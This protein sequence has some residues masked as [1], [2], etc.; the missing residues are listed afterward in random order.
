MEKYAGSNMPL[1]GLP[2]AGKGSAP[3][4]AILSIVLGAIAAL[5]VNTLPVLLTVLARTLS[6]DESQS[7][8]VAFAEM[9]GIA[10]GTIGCA[11]LARLVA[12]LTWRWTTA[13]GLALLIAANLMCTQITDFNL[14]LLARSVAGIGSGLVLA[15]TYASLAARGGAR[16][17]AIF[18]IMQLG[19]GWLGMPYLGPIAEHYGAAGLFILFAGIAFAA[20]LCSPF[21]PARSDEAFTPTAGGA[22]STPGWLA[23]LSALLYFAGVGAIYAYA[24]FMGVAWGGAQA[25][26]ESQV[27]TMMF[28][29][30][31]GGL[32]V[33]LAGSRFGLKG[34][35]CGAYLLLLAAMVL[36]AVTKPVAG[37]LPVICLFGFAWN[38]VTP[39]QFEAVTAV[40]S[41][42]SAAMLVNASTLGGLALGPA[43]AA[44]F[45]TGTYL[46]VNILAVAG[47][48]GSFLL[49][50]V[51]LGM[52][53]RRN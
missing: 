43:V 28:A 39:Y 47:V 53:Q 34:P 16:A 5:S 20:L 13:L 19:C 48:L 15:V 45:V 42:S 27:A 29:G 3:G 32:V 33:A 41:S 1:N 8:L 7:G 10:C 30:M 2:V 36:L 26:V 21:L 23:I 50:L 37:F 49:L 44:S 17:L 24:A 22:V 11:L 25:T 46:Q 31:L 35:L 12:R 4:S 52:H 51:A 18:N 6:L 14:L 38:I 40:D 9:G